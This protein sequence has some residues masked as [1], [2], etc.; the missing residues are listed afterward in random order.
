MAPIGFTMAP[1]LATSAI[2]A[3]SSGSSSSQDSSSASGI[4]FAIVL[5]IALGATIALIAVP[6]VL[7]ATISSL[8]RCCRERRARRRRRRHA[9]RNTRASPPAVRA[10][11][12]WPGCAHAGTKT[13]EAGEGYR[14]I[15][16]ANAAGWPN[17]SPADV[18]RDPFELTALQWPAK[19]G[20]VS[21][22]SP[23]VWKSTPYKSPR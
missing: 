22:A 21:S 7:Y 5:P 6:L 9:R 17:P 14:N 11:T 2:L 1:I 18:L 3:S 15:A 20:L 19:P 12:S 10:T 8:I 4:P 16:G 13:G 23:Y